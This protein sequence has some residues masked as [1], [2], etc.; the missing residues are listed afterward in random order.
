MNPQQRPPATLQ[1]IA[2]GMLLLMVV[3]FIGAIP[4]GILGLIF[5]NANNAQDV[6]LMVGAILSAWLPL[7]LLVDSLVK[8]RPNIQLPRINAATLIIAIFGSI[9]IVPVLYGLTF[10]AIIFAAL[11]YFLT[12]NV[13]LGLLVGLGVQ[14]A[15]IYRGAQREKAMGVNNAFFMRMQ[16]MSGGF[17]VTI[18][19]ENVSRQQPRTDQ[20]QV[21]FLPEDRLRD[22]DTSEQNTY[23]D[24][25]DYDENE[26][27]S[28]ETI[29]DDAPADG[30]I[31]INL[32]D[33]KNTDADG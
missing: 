8:E 22:N 17:D 15:N 7:K 26:A 33:R 31:T 30:E 27:A 20:P 3:G 11:T 13:I 12:Q 32:A 4:F 6:F 5:G 1:D 19:A 24:Y 28:Y 29:D 2:L 9:V 25:Y 16:D 10:T 23:N 21:I 18:N 14:A